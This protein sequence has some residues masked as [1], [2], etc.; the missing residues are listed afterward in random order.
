MFTHSLSGAKGGLIFRCAESIV[1]AEVSAFVEQVVG[2]RVGQGA[3]WCPA[4]RVSVLDVVEYLGDEFRLSDV[5]DVAKLA[6]AQ[7]AQC[8]VDFK[9][10]L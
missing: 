2:F 10:A 7:R 3:P 1:V 4:R 9:N 6:T 5:C 8:D